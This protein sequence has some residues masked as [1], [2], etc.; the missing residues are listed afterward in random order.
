MEF[1]IN[2]AKT[3]VTKTGSTNLERVLWIEDLVQNTLE[4]KP[5]SERLKGQWYNILIILAHAATE[6][7]DEANKDAFYCAL[8]RTIVSKSPDKTL[9]LR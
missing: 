9:M 6:E 3:T 5:I 4:F 1:N 2:P 8:E 7:K